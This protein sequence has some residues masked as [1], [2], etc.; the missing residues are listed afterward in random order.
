MRRHKRPDEN[1]T[2]EQRQLLQA[3]ATLRH[4]HAVHPSPRELADSLGV[5]V[6]RVLAVLHG[7]REAGVVRLDG[8][9][10]RVGGR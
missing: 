4:R 6:N 1:L 5:S 9:W 2:G 7:L 8:E 10:L 3:I